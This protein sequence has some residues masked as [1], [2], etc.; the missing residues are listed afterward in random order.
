MVVS[1]SSEPNDREK[2]KTVTDASSYP[3]QQVLPP[4]ETQS[5]F[6]HDAT[7]NDIRLSE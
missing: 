6:L 7:Y 4:A 2:P 5:F 3:R 1:T